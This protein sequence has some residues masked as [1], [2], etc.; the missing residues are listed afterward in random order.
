MLI[1]KIKTYVKWYFFNFYIREQRVEKYL[2]AF[3][4]THITYTNLISIIVVSIAHNWVS[5]R[6]LKSAYLTNL[7]FKKPLLL[8]NKLSYYIKL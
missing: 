2:W 8:E 3:E 1:C 4:N 5:L 6:I 7:K